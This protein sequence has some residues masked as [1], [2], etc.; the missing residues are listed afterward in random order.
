[1]ASPGEN[2]KL[3]G[4]K[5]PNGK[6]YKT[7]HNCA[8]FRT[9]HVGYG[10]CFKHGGRTPKQ[11]IG[12]ELEKAREGCMRLG[13]P[14]GTNPFDSLVKLQAE[15]MGTVEYFR[16]QVEA[17]DPDM[18]FVRP[19][20]ILRR[21]LGEGSAGENPGIVVEEITEAP[22]ELNVKYKAW[23]EARADLERVA[24][25][26]AQLGL[27]ERMVRL[28]EQLKDRDVRALTRF[29]K[30]LGVSADDPKTDKAIKRFLDSIDGTCEED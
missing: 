30:E 2:I 11:Q 16:R 4:A 23:R 13:T 21:P 26:I 29:L 12:A 24:K 22:V 10:H 8:G 28:E 27:A 5:T 9:E 25:T 14:V 7:C 19:T 1:M 17:L 6:K 20:S 3:C 15:A 18:V